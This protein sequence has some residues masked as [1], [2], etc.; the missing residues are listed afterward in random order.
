MN[1]KP[2]STGMRRRDFMRVAAAGAAIIGAANTSAMGAEPSE[3]ASATARQPAP[4][5]IDDET[6][7]DILVPRR[8]G[9]KPR[10]RDRGRR[11]QF[12]HRSPAQA[13]RQDPLYRGA[14]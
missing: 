6:T 7:A 12:D 13:P 3:G 5:F 9:R 8:L 4:V 10:I 2:G 14:T 1:Q 11:H